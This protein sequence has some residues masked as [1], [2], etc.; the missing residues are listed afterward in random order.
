M[1]LQ[2]FAKHHAGWLTGNQISRL[3]AA[4]C[5]LT[6]PMASES[7]PLN[8]LLAQL[9]YFK[10]HRLHFRLQPPRPLSDKSISPATEKIAIA[11]R[12]GILNP[13]AFP[14]KSARFRNTWTPPESGSSFKRRRHL[15]MTHRV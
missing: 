6:V 13:P 12:A 8:W 11:R 9:F 3:S 4:F 7:T 2:G 14:K 15:Q 10:R 5:L 1:K